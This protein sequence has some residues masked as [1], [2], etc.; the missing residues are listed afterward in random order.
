MRNLPFESRTPAPG[1]VGLFFR[2]HTAGK[3][4]EDGMAIAAIKFI[5][6]HIQASC[7][8]FE[9]FMMYCPD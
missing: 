5:D 1:A 9:L 2:V 7:S 6:R 8:I 3:K 4:I